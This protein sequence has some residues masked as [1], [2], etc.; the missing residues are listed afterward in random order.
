M[1]HQVMQME[2]VSCYQARGDQS[3]IHTW[4]EIDTSLIWHQPMISMA[5]PY[6][7][8]G[9]HRC[10]QLISYP[11]C[12]EVEISIYTIHM[13]N[14]KIS[15][16]PDINSSNKHPHYTAATGKCFLTCDSIFSNNSALRE[17]ST[18]LCCT[19]FS[20]I[21]RHSRTDS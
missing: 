5:L 13:L 3:D 17:S 14:H 16:Q 7:L 21:M 6:S 8:Y 4:S 15:D 1:H 19:L 9:L 18:Q 2:A 20:A 11:L 12:H 10:K